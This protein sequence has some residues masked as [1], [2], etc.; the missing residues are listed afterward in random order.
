MVDS[1]FGS[2]HMEYVADILILVTLANRAPRDLKRPPM[3]LMSVPCTPEVMGIMRS[4]RYCTAAVV[5]SDDGM[6]MQT[7]TTTL[8]STTHQAII[9]GNS[10][11]VA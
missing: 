10:S 4:S 8:D 7:R 6:H 1:P 11:G 9:A 3:G 5:I 2:I